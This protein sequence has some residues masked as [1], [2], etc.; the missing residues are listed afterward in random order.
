MK[1]TIALQIAACL[2]ASAQ[3]TEVQDCS[4]ICFEL[5]KTY[6]N[7]YTDINVCNNHCCPTTEFDISPPAATHVEQNSNDTASEE[8]KKVPDTDPACNLE[9]FNGC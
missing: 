5:C 4:L 2:Y 8:L 3:A 1:N 9:M 7:H 6:A